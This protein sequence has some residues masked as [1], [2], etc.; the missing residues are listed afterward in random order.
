VQNVLMFCQFF[1]A[2]AAPPCS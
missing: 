1:R 2:G